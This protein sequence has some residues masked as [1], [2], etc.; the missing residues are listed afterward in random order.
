LKQNSNTISIPYK[1]YQQI[2][3]NTEAKGLNKIM[4]SEKN[5]LPKT[6]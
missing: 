1:S 5:K 3:G 6:D 2:E 4:F